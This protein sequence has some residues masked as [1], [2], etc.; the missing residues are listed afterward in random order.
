MK[1]FL[2]IQECSAMRALA[3]LS[4][5]LHNYTHW[6]PN[7]V[8]ENEFTYRQERNTQFWQ[9]LQL[10]ND[11]F[12]LHIMSYLGHYG[13]IIFLFLSGFGVV[14]KYEKGNISEIKTWSFIRYNYLKLWRIF[15]VGFIAFV[16]ID[17]I[18]KRMHFYSFTDVVAML[19]LFGNLLDSPSQ[20][21][22]PGPY[23][24]FGIT[25]Q[26]YVIYCLILYR[27]RYW[28]IPLLLIIICWLWQSYYIGDHQVITYL[29]YNFVG[30][31]LPF[32]IG[33]LLARF[34]KEFAL[35]QFIWFAIFLISVAAILAL[36]FTFQGWLWAPVFV[37]IAMLALIKVLSHQTISFLTK[38]GNIS[39]AIFI[40]H[41]IARKIFIFTEYSNSNVYAGL[42]LYVVAS[43]GLAWVAQ[44]IIEQLP[45]PKL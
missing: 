36:C 12:L 32:C 42:L 29:R 28:G 25:L 5:M 1:N 30:G 17:A 26:L 31:I 33:I 10:Y 21:I 27:Y 14:M 9:A 4:I 16:L 7:I 23:W 15:I 41:P 3:I 6:L 11:D 35:N 44:K 18:T 19:G 37:I 45:N 38:V 24:Y 8:K 34:V 40:M 39:A 43:I 22:W 20:S 2:S 13:V